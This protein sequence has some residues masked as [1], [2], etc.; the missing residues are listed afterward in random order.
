MSPFPN[1]RILLQW[2]P[3][4]IKV[5]ARGVE[6][7][8]A[9]HTAHQLIKVSLPPSVSAAAQLSTRRRFNHLKFPNFLQ[10]TPLWRGNLPSS[11]N[12]S[13]PRTWAASRFPL[14]LFQRPWNCLF[15][16]RLNR[17]PFTQL[18]P[19]GQPSQHA[20]SLRAQ[21]TTGRRRD[22]HK[23]LGLNLGGGFFFPQWQLCPWR[24]HGGGVLA[25]RGRGATLK[26]ALR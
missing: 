25:T 14:S 5:M 9:P 16:Q 15:S 21:A 3:A 11:P 4:T 23:P 24:Q 12:P 2:T 10:T 19:W 6:L 18:L 17:R 1:H 8:T 7:Q 20:S 26:A 22:V 13:S